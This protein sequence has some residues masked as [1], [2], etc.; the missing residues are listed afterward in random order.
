MADRVEHRLE[1]VREIDQRLESEHSGATL[2]RMDG[3]KH[4][5][6]GVLRL[7]AMAH[8]REARVDRLEPLVGFL[9]ERLLQ[10]VPIRHDRESLVD[11]QPRQ[12]QLL[13]FGCVQA[14]GSLRRQGFAQRD[15]KRIGSRQIHHGGQCYG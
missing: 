10:L 9:E 2:D 14:A 3:A 1:H 13:D 5:V 12:H 8:V 7:G 4:G 15:Q 11:L 6:D